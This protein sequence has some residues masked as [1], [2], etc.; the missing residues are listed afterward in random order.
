MTRNPESEAGSL[1]CVCGGVV[2]DWNRRSRRSGT[3]AECDTVT[4]PGLLMG[5]S[6]DG[7]SAPQEAACRS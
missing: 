1:G 7:P 2:G 3:W 6:K 4:D 5:V